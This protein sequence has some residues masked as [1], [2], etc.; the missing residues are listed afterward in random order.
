MKEIET[1]DFDPVFEKI[2]KQWM[3]LAAEKDGKANMMTA[4]WGEMGELWG[5]YVVVFHVRPQRF[6]KTLIDATDRVSVSFLPEEYRKA[7]NYCGSAT[8]RNEDKIAGSG[9]TLTHVDG[10]PCFEEAE[11]TLIVRKLYAQE[12]D[13]KCFID[14]SLLSRWYP[15]NDFHTTYVAAIEKVLP[16]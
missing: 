1:R 14:T 11:A 16:V 8:G 15:D 2:G 7:L 6:T 3:L 12:M 10:V 4:S 5:Q 9:L 13:P